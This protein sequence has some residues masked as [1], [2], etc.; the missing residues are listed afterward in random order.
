MNLKKK[1]YSINIY[2]MTTLYEY[3][4]DNTEEEGD[5]ASLELNSDGN[6]EMITIVVSDSEEKPKRPR[7]RP[8]QE[9]IPSEPSEPVEKK[10]KGRKK[11]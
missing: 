4:R 8:K 9:K 2:R 11:R 10:K 1:I 6:N 5:K 3:V 7:G